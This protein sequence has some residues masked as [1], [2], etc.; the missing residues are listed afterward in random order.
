MNK[1]LSGT[2]HKIRAN[3]KHLYNICKI[4]VQRRNVGPTLYKCYTNVLRLLGLGDLF[5]LQ[6]SLF[7]HHAWVK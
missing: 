7:D 6:K 2:N 3:T 4:L 5:T 1:K